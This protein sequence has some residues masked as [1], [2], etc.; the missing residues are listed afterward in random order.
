MGGDF[1]R[2]FTNLH[3]ILMRTLKVVV[4]V[5]LLGVGVSCSR[6][7][8]VVKKKYVESG[9]RYF[10]KGKFKEA[11]IMYRR[12]LAKDRR[13]GEAYYRLGLCDLKLGNPSSAYRNFIRAVET[14]PK[15][16]DAKIQAGQ[17]AMFG[18]LQNPMRNA[19]LAADWSQFARDIISR[20]SENPDG[21]RLLGYYTLV[22]DKHPREALLDFRRANELKPNRPNIVL[23]L[24]ET[25]FAVNQNA[26]AEKTARELISKD[27]TVLGMYDILYVY[28]VKSKRLPE[29]EGILKLKVA[30]NP[31]NITPILQ[32]AAHYQLSQRKADARATIARLM[33]DSESFPDGRLRAGQFFMR[34]RDYDRAQLAF[35]EGIRS[36]PER[37]ADYQKAL[38]DVFLVQQRSDD[39]RRVLDEVLRDNP[40][41]EQAKSVRAALMLATGDPGQVRSAMSE[42]QSGIKENPKNPVSRFNYGR[43]LLLNGQI[44]EA[45]AQFQEAIRLNDRYVAPRLTLGELQYAQGEFGAARSSARDILDHIDPK[46]LPARLL[47]T[48]SLEASG[49]RVRARELLNQILKDNPDS[50]EAQIQMGLVELGEQRYKDAEA[51]FGKF[52]E[53]NSS[54]VRGLIGLAETYAAQ[55]QWDRAFTLLKAEL[56]KDPKRDQ[57]RAVLGSIA[58]RAKRYDEAI[59]FYRELVQHNPKAGEI[60]MR[61]G[62]CY[63]EKGDLIE[64]AKYYQQARQLRPNDPEAHL[65]LAVLFD[66]MGRR[67]EAKLI[68]EQVLRLNPEHPYALN[69]LAY[70]ITETGGDLSQALSLAQRARLRMPDHPDVADTLGWILMRQNLND[71][72]IRVFQELVQKDPNR[73]TF[74]YHLGAALYQKG[75]RV[76]AKK[77]LQTALRL[78]QRQPQKDEEAKVR[79]LIQVVDSR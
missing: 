26:E 7:P 55:H 31:K 21:L 49:D 78:L 67:A 69:N 18:Y 52:Y 35:E 51:L 10:E 38:A 42:L 62:D 66:S 8:D 45:K 70:L 54:D 44:E 74:H 25:L 47:E 60:Y 73:S 72:A 41:D 22:I 46:N 64:A 3:V 29:A 58:F 23:P 27:K 77:E 15:N 43:A 2:Y 6:D 68:Y 57:I 4:C 12:A 79:E 9:N 14:E 59:A 16:M 33:S 48:S 1:G 11:H 63:R 53:S 56:A 61:I 71:A 5:L 30:N 17:L 65:Q 50:R 75:D 20:D 34:I 37:K 76:G 36:D 24:V 19:A 32:L 28:L 13:Y 40:K 39:A